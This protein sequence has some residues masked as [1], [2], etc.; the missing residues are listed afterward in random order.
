MKQ[1]GQPT[2][3]NP[4]VVFEY[5][6]IQQGTTSGLRPAKKEISNKASMNKSGSNKTKG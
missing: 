4:G 1:K 3:N 6:T 5:T 2:L